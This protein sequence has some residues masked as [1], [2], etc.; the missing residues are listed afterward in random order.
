MLIWWCWLRYK[1]KLSIL[2][3]AVPKSMDGIL[4]LISQTFQ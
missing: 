3:H 4:E 2:C 1:L